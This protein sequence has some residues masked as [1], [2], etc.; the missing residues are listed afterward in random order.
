MLDVDVCKGVGSKP[1]ANKRR[2]RGGGRKTGIFYMSFMG[3]SFGKC[4][5]D[6][7]RTFVQMA[8]LV[9]CPCRSCSVGP[10]TGQKVGLNR[11]PNFAW[12][13]VFEAVCRV[14]STDTEYLTK[15][16]YF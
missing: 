7:D 6:V 15:C 4:L 16:K 14:P 13:R 8:V 5:N 2:Q 12:Y 1:H 11:V 9:N 10:D 3:D